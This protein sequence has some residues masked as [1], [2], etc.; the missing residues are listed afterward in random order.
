MARWIAAFVTASCVASSPPAQPTVQQPPPPPETRTAVQPHAIAPAPRVVPSVPAQQLL[1][2]TDQL[3]TARA[4]LDRASIVRA[5]YALADALEAVAPEHPNE[6][7][8]MRQVT[9]ELTRSDQ[10]ADTGSDLVRIALDA[11]TRALANVKRQPETDRVRLE[12][13]IA[14]LRDASA[15]IDPDRPL[16]AQFPAVRSAFRASVRAVYAAT[17]AP[18]P[19]IANPPQTARR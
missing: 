16:R 1:V 18:D 14:A 5:L 13:A 12:E 7:L 17:G 4:R 8:R 6:I 3:D 19:E 10:R 15:G 9:N 2:A 11:A